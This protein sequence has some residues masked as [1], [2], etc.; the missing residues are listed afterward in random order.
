MKKIIFIEGTPGVG[1]TT[2]V[3]RL[4][5]QNNHSFR[6]I[7]SADVI[8]ENKVRKA[9]KEGRT[10]SLDQARSI[11]R[12]RSYADYRQEHL[13][14]WKDF[15]MRN[16][17]GDDTLIVDAGLIQAPLYELMGLYMLSPEQILSHI[18]QVVDIVNAHFTAELVYIRTPYPAQC[19]RNAIRQQQEQRSSWVKGFC[20]WLEVAPYPMQKGYSGP[21][22]IEQFVVDRSIIDLYLIDNLFVEK[23]I[24]SRDCV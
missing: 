12:Q 21:C 24:Y 20:T 13:E 8:P 17:S 11:Y 9:I 4:L 3:N 1:K 14:I 18:Q 7:Y 16:N 23:K 19:I 22:G 10:L 5:A 2:Y 6:I 15:C